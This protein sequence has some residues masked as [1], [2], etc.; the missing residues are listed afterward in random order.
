MQRNQRSSKNGVVMAKISKEQY[1]EKFYKIYSMVPKYYSKDVIENAY[2]FDTE[3]NLL[4]GLGVTTYE[5]LLNIC[6]KQINDIRLLEKIEKRLSARI[7]TDDKV[8]FV[9]KYGIDNYSIKN[10]HT[11]IDDLELSVRATNVLENLNVEYVSDLIKMTPGE[12]KTARNMGTKSYREIFNIIDSEVQAG[13]SIDSCNYQKFTIPYLFLDHKSDILNGDLSFCDGIELSEAEVN[14]KKL[15]DESFSSISFDLITSII[16]RNPAGIAIYTLLNEIV[17]N[18]NRREQLKGNVNEL[19]AKIP[20]KR[21]ENPYKHYIEAYTN[22]ES[23]RT[24]LSSVCHGSDG[25]IQEFCRSDNIYEREY[26]SVACRFL[27]WCAFDLHGEIESTIND[28]SIEDRAKAILKLR[29]SGKTLNEIGDEYNITRERVRQ[30]ERKTKKEMCKR[31]NK[32]KVIQKIY[33][34]RGGDEVL[35]RTELEEYFGENTQLVLYALRD[36]DNQAFYY[37]SALNVLVVENESLTMQVS[38][39]IETIPEAFNSKDLNKII[40]EGVEEYSLNKEFLEKAIT[41]EYDITGRIYHRNRLTLKQIYKA[42]VD[43]YYSDGIALYDPEAIKHLREDI[44]HE[45]GNIELP[46]KDRAISAR[47][48]DV[49]ILY[50]RGVYKPKSKYYISKSLLN[51]IINYI[52][53]HDSKIISMSSL[54]F[55]FEK[56]LREEGVNNKYYLQGILHELCSDQYDFKRDYLFKAGAGDSFYTEIVEFIRKSQN[57][58]TKEEILAHFPGLTDIVIQFATNDSEILNFFG[59]YMHSSKIKFTNTEIQYL[60]SEIEKGIEAEGYIHCQ[61]LFDAIMRKQ[62]MMLKRNGIF[63]QYSLFS[64]LR[65]LFESYFQFQRPYIGRLGCVINSPLEMI[66]E[67]TENKDVVDISQIMEFCKS[68]HLTIPHKIDLINDMSDQYLMSDKD[69]IATY[70]YLGLNSNI[71]KR[72]VLQLN[73][74][75]MRQCQLEN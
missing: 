10:F 47:L 46:E 45:Y 58:V 20:Q 70:E 1:D 24:I 28:M 55:I 41:E 30:I 57:L 7:E 17:G 75:L 6:P 9:E 59:S 15:L 29:A 60:K 27:K 42:I 16:N 50:D 67:V 72:I 65:Y 73:K 18:Y 54:F 33:A 52:N 68:K 11:P 48:A 4:K 3:I 19:V 61:E 40:N 21:K 23:V 34:D 25:T 2:F 32:N 14:Y 35:T 26:Y 51:K 12:L 39:Y 44:K 74:K 56:E 69:H 53:N 63:Y 62:E 64:T 31:L 36:E 49:C 66:S 5:E 13:A 71:I 37:D 38:N 43:K 22:D 8:S